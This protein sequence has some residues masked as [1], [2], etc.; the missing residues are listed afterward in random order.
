M[1][2][3][4]ISSLNFVL[5]VR[6]MASLQDN[7]SSLSE[8]MSICNNLILHVVDETTRFQAARWLSNVSAKHTWDT[9]QLYWINVY[10]GTPDYIHHD[11]GKN[12]VSKKFYQFT[13]S[14]VITTKSV[15]VKAYWSIKIVKRYYMVLRQ[16]YKIIMKD[17][18]GTGVSKEIILQIAVKAVNDTARLNS[19]VSMLLVFGAYPRILT[20]DPPALTII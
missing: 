14:M 18:Q 2:L 3:H 5:S 7:S 13:T 19:L 10:L 6:S 4:L 8:K 15:S 11:A 12:F 17:L 16:A 1:S 9:L 20:M